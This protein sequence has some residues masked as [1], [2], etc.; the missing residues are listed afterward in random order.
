MTLYLTRRR[1]SGAA[2]LGPQALPALREH[3]LGRAAASNA[4][5]ATR[6]A[7]A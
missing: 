3:R 1:F 4:W 5:W 7:G 6:P 2:A